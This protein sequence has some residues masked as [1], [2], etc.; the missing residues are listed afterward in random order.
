MS[1]DPNLELMAR[2]FA[3]LAD[4]VVKRFGEEGREAIRHGVRR[5]GEGRGADIAR[6]AREDGAE[7]TVRNYLE[8]YD[9]QRDAGFKVRT[10]VEGDR[11][12]QVFE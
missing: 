5:F 1:R 6:R 8:Y 3:T 2:L 7:L 9:M 4:E 12:E 10:E 11:A